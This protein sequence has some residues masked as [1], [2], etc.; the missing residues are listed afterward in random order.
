MQ[1]RS[2]VTRIPTQTFRPRRAGGLRV[3]L[4]GCVGVC[5]LG[6]ILPNASGAQVQFVQN[7]RDDA[8]GNSLAAVASTQWL[9]TG[10][11][12][13]TVT[14]AVSHSSYRF[15]H[16]SSS[17]DPAEL[18]RDPWGRSQNPIS[19]ILLEN[20]T[21]TA[22]YLPSA[23]DTDDDGVPDGYEAEY[24]NALTN[25]ADSD[26]DGDGISLLAEYEGGTHPLYGNG[27]LDGGVAYAD[28]SNLTVNL[29]GYSWYS[30]TSVPTGAVHQA[31]AVPDGTTVTSP[32]LSGNGAF[33]Y[34][35][36][37]GVR[38]QDAW[39]VAQPQ[40]SFV[41]QG[42]SR[43]GIAYLFAGDGDGDGVP[44]A[45]EEYYFGTLA[46]DADADADGDGISL[47]AEYE[48]G[49]PPQ[50]G[51]C[52]AEGGVFWADSS[53]LTVN[54]AGYSQYRLVSSPTGA[55]NQSATVLDGTTVAT[56]NM[57]QASFGY[58]TLDGVPQRDAWGVALRQ[59][60]FVVDGADR[61]GV[62]CLFPADSDGDGVNDGFEYFHYGNLD[63][64]ADSDTDGDGVSLLAE[65]A[66]STSP[67]FG[68]SRTEG[69]IFW[70][71]SDLLVANLQP[72]E[73][74]RFALVDS[75]LT[76]I[77]S[78]DPNAVTGWDV[79]DESAV[80]LGDW[81]GDEDLDVFLANEN[82]LKVYENVGTRRTMNLSERTDRF[83]GLSGLVA[84]IDSPVLAM[85]DWDGDG[86]EDLAIGGHT[87]AVYCVKSSGNY[88]GAQP[89]VAE[90]RL[91]TGSTRALPGLGDLDGD[92][93]ADLLA[94]LADGTVRAYFHSGS[95]SVPYAAFMT[96]YLGEAV[97]N[98]SGIGI[99]NVDFAGLPDVLVA[100]A[101]GRLWEF[102]NQGGG[103][104]FLK[105]KVW[106]G[107]HQGFASQMAI[108]PRDL[109]G[110]GD[111]DLLAGMENGGLIGLRDPRVR[112]PTGLTATPGATSITLTWDPDPQS[113]I[114]GYHIYRAGSETGMFVRLNATLLTEPRCEDQSAAAAT[115]YWYYVTGVTEA[116]YPGNSHPVT[117]E[118]AA[119]DEVSVPADNGL[120]H[121]VLRVKPGRGAPGH[122]VKIRLVLDQSDGIRGEGMELRVA[123]PAA[124]LTP[125]SQLETNAETV[126]QSGLSRN[127]VLTNDSA[128]ASGSFTIAG[129]AGETRPGKGTFLT[130]NFIMAESV[131]PGTQL[132]VVVSSATM[133]DGAGN[134]LIVTIVPGGIIDVDGTFVDGDL[135]GDG[136]V[137]SRDEDLLKEL[138]KPH[139]REATEE[140]LQAGDLNG[141]GELDQQDW[142]LLK[143][144]LAGKSGE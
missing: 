136:I 75:L 19:F 56:P 109:D 94:V 53:N 36:L 85:G 105:S 38:Q 48:G 78:F 117:V 22:H 52:R 113:R 132:G 16:W 139:A 60:D 42:T 62:A 43:E 141:D 90:H 3:F 83:A 122:N 31:A 134:P 28:S 82:G 14:A 124:D 61:E 1:R 71:D 44:D 112:R 126:L 18:Y 129:S 30:L 144:L 6:L 12:Y 111:T 138:I 11:A 66:G 137:D 69:G 2:Y 41:L 135:T 33:G 46:Q 79:G 114:K 106:A 110:D 27:R 72:F 116:F 130:L 5:W 73:R 29:A 101:A 104:F 140:E 86:F 128:V 26:P 95:N 10:V 49:T 68:S 15:T 76:E 103:S 39:G 89:I 37:D 108:A 125:R 32:D 92:G 34:W 120:G 133:R 45:Y 23:R 123:Y 64:G 91:D 80:A 142:L 118:S 127:L 47:L 143:R 88:T 40:I 17:S 51:S 24:F 87:G 50:I 57:A 96:D 20:T 100:D 55:V 121:V 84:E 25:E 63:N 8:S 35:E 74:L 59:F 119:S 77:Y 102:H 9:E 13:T 98:A 21:N 67:N 7:A 115:E 107:A 4:L 99:A 97:T 58:W 65:Y 81:D 70:A 93:H 54:L 131:D